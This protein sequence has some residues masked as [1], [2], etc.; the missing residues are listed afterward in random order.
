MAKTNVSTG[1]ESCH[2]L[3]PSERE[4][5]VRRKGKRKK[6]RKHVVEAKCPKDPQHRAIVLKTRGT[7]RHCFCEE[8]NKPFVMSGPEYKKWLQEHLKLQCECPKSSRHAA[9]VY[10]QSDEEDRCKCN[11]CGHM[12]T[13]PR[14][15]AEVPDRPDDKLHID[16]PVS[17][18]R[19][20]LRHNAIVYEEKKNVLMCKCDTCGHMWTIAK[21]V[22]DKPKETFIES[23][24]EGESAEKPARPQRRRRQNV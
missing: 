8:C 9:V 3:P 10:A 24:G 13:Q 6:S 23:A 2:H 20:P 22:D 4:K 21:E 16:D 11:S 17:C 5:I 14:K 12:W 18:P 15:D 1:D 7:K 19:N